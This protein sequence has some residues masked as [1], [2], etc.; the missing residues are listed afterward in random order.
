MIQISGVPLQPNEECNLECIERTIIQH[1]LDC[2]RLIF[3]LNSKNNKQISNNSEEKK[4]GF[5]I[6]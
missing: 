1:M 4:F 3:L 6:Q 2:S 5:F